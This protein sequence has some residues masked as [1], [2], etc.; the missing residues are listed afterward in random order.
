MEIRIMTYGGTLLS[1]RVPDRDGR[2]ADVV[3][4]FDSLAPYLGEHPY[5]GGI[6]GRY[7]NRIAGGSFSLDGRIY[8]LTQNEG[9]NHLHGG[10]LGFHRQLWR[11]LPQKTR[12]ADQLVLH[13]LSR[14]GE[15]GYPGDLHVEVIYTL[16]ARNELR[17]DYHA[18]VD[19]PTIINLTHHAY[20][21]LGGGDTILDH[22]LT[23]TA[24]RYLPVDGLLIP[25]GELAPV[26]D[27]PMD[28]RTPTP[29]GSRIHEQDAQLLRASGGY[30]HC[31]ALN[32]DT[33]ILAAEL[34][35]SFSGRKLHVY[36]TQPGVQFYSG[37]FFD[38]SVVG[39]EGHAYGKY[40]GL[41]LEPQHFPD[42]PNQPDFPSTVLGPHDFYQHSTIYAFDVA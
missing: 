37:N 18:Q 22:V 7:A 38:G 8:Q 27:T 24:D 17:V 28:F 21:N 9:P 42:S 41:C 11:A 40:A 35:D 34:Y 31:W 26:A 3:L 10:T 4:G 32:S 2:L 1:L 30:D 20:F 36:T 29:I 12:N 6:I 13:Y 33:G 25:T 39:K 23:L 5:L 19:R 16:T 14:D 15:E